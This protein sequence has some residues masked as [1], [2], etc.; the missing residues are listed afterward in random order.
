MSKAQNIQNDE[1][2]VDWTYIAAKP[3]WS[4]IILYIIRLGILC[5]KSYQWFVKEKTTNT[6]P[7]PP[8][9]PEGT[10]R[11]QFFLKKGRVTMA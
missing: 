10:S 2:L 8:R 1:T 7:E 4:A 11:A 3:S 6:L 5:W 9:G